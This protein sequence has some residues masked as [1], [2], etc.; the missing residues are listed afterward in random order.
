MKMILT[1]NIPSI[2]YLNDVLDWKMTEDEIQEYLSTW[3]YD[4][5]VSF[6]GYPEITFEN[7]TKEKE[8]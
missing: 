5:L 7:S 2:K 3:P 8:N 1:F 4:E 6:L